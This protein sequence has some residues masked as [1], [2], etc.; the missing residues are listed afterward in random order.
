MQSQEDG[1]CQPGLHYSASAC[2]GQESHHGKSRDSMEVAPWCIHP[3]GGQLRAQ[4]RL[5]ACLPLALEGM[6]TRYATINVLAPSSRPKCR[7]C[8]Q[9]ES[10]T[11]R[12]AF[13]LSLHTG[14]FRKR[15]GCRRSVMNKTARRYSIFP[16]STCKL[17]FKKRQRK[18]SFL[19]EHGCKQKERIH[20]YKTGTRMYALTVET[21]K[22]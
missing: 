17:S 16:L 2:A 9:T 14:E 1:R 6:S 20:L 18:G 8:K 21:G 19:Q 11:S 10:F 4:C 5:P 22:S 7:R 13:L 15:K 3:M 12:K